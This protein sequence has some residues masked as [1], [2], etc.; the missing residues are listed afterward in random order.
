VLQGYFAPLTL[1]QSLSNQAGNVFAAGRA[2]ISPLQRLWCT[3]LRASLPD[4]FDVLHFPKGPAKRVTGMGTF[5]FALTAKS[6]HPDEAWARFHS[7]MHC[8]WRISGR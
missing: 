1:I 8:S 2:A 4:D 5:G 6:K 3:N 7:G